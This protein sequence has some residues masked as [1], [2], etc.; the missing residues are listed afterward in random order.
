MLGKMILHT[1]L[2]AGLIAGASGLYAASA[3]AADI[4]PTTVPAAAPTAPPQDNGYLPASAATSGHRHDDDHH[5]TRTKDGHGVLAA[6]SRRD[7]DDDD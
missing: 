4:A 3:P 2:A 6:K 1:L 7:H 5:E